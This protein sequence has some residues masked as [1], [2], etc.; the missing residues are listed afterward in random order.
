NKKRFILFAFLNALLMTAFTFI[1]LA[2]P[3][4]SGDEIHLIQYTSAFKRLLFT[5]EMPP[6]DRFVFVDIAWE[7]ELIDKIDNDFPIGKQSIV[8]RQ[9][10]YAFFR[11]LD[12]N[13]VKPSFI[14]CDVSFVEASDKGTDSLLCDVLQKFPNL[15]IAA[16]KGDDSV[17]IPICKNVPYGITHYETIEETKFIKFPLVV[18]SILSLPLK[19]YMQLYRKNYAQGRFFNYLDGKPM[20]SNPIIDLR[21]R[22]YN[23]KKGESLQADSTNNINL[24]N[25]PNNNVQYHKMYISDA[26]A[27]F[28]SV[29]DATD[30]QKLF[31]NKIIVIGDFE[32]R[33]IKETIYGMTPGA[34]IL[35]NVFLSVEA[36]D[37]IISIWFMIFLIVGYWLISLKWFI[38]TDIVESFLTRFFRTKSNFLFGLVSYLGLLVLMSVIS[39]YL[40]SIHLT[41]LVLALYLN[42]VGNV[43]S[44]RIHG[45]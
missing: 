41:I 30:I 26:L 4:W 15:L 28:E 23:L 14:I 20:I 6:T 19:M 18:D 33:D 2:S 8:S 25:D 5:K 24:A 7:K 35:L 11:E 22:N 1:W 45:T 13:N 27:T 42:L 10:L 40:F 17:I 3:F 29:V 36:G 16:E 39:Y 21:I 37:N 44:R 9:S 32:D 12:E 38:K 31:N 43:I 34:L